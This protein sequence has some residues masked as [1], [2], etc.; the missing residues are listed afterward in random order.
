M[1]CQ[2]FAN[3]AGS[4]LEG[5]NLPEAQS[6][7]AACPRCR[8]LVDELG[9]IERA[10]RDLSFTE[11]SARLWARLETTATREG[12]W[13]R[14]RSAGWQWS[15]P[16][17][18]LVPA[19]PAFAGLLGLTVLVAG[20]LVGYSAAELSAPHTAP[21]TPFEVAQ[22]ELVQEAGY[23]TRYELHL[24]QVEQNVTG[25]AAPQDAQLRELTTGPLNDV[26]R[27]IEQTQARLADDPDD[28]LAREELHR[29]YR[30]KATVLQ[31]MSDPVW[32]EG[33]P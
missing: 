3:I 1:N 29:L 19:R 2:E 8:L 22:G 28:P 33:S 10:A 11:P 21:V 4:L 30:Q 26:D 18:N 17:W 14:S 15:G 9:A 7:L 32:Q 23:A 20:W 27:A 6:H 24:Q 12:L 25:Q 13:A 31:A 16:L 5:E